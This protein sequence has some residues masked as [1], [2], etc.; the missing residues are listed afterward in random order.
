MIFDKEP[1]LDPHSIGG[2]M[3]LDLSLTATGW[4]YADN[5]QAH[6][7]YGELTNRMSGKGRL[8]WVTRK[9]CDLLIKHKPL[10]IVLEALT[11][12]G[13]SDVP[14]CELTGLIKMAIW[15]YQQANYDQPIE[16]RIMSPFEIKRSATQNI[17]ANKMAMIQAANRKYKINLNKK[18]HNEADA[19]A[20]LGCVFR[21]DYQ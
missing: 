8:R 19:L 21:E 10:T 3:G 4:A 13:Y 20:A 6:P 15:E 16:L 5:A 12:K 1:K 18:Q 17:H 7:V 2:G 14:S 11:L 9:V